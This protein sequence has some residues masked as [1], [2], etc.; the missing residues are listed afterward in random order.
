MAR[1]K[2]C[3]YRNKLGQYLYKV[4]VKFKFWPF[5]LVCQISDWTDYKDADF[6]TFREAKKYKRE[7]INCDLKGSWTRIK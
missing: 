2:I 6:T 7:R 5:W 3:K 4:K 1:Y